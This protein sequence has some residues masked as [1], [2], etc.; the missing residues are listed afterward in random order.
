MNRKKSTG[1]RATNEATAP[2]DAGN[3]DASL[4]ART[5]LRPNV[6]AAIT[7]AE[8]G[9]PMAKLDTCSLLE[10]LEEQTEACRSGDWKRAEEMLA[11]QA[12]TLDGIFN[13]LAR[14][15]LKAEYVDHFERYLRL[16]LRAQSQAR[17]TWET[18][19]AIKNPPIMGYVRQANIAHGPQQVNNA[20][21]A[22]EDVPR[23]GENRNRQSRL[24]EEH[25]GNRLDTRTARAASGVDTPMETVGAIHRAEDG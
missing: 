5:S 2:D 3:E 4:I 1:K 9:K 24:L 14:Q 19:A 12:H 8:Y 17:T 7:L 13:N 11:A 15:A 20:A 21:S 10:G 18:L 23:A 22:P 25:D 6:Q 16:A